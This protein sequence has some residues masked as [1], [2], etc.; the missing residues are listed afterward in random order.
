MAPVM[1][2]VHSAGRSL[3]AVA[4]AVAGPDVHLDD[5]SDWTLPALRS[6]SAPQ[7]AGKMPTGT[8]REE[9]PCRA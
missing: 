3:A 8:R 1:L 5:Y 6:G 2:H 7:C 4:G 9:R